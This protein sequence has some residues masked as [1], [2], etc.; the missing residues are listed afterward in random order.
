[1]GSMLDIRR[2]I[3]GVRNIRQ[4]TK[5]MEMVAAAKLRR[6]QDQ[7]VAARP[8][9]G[10]IRKALARLA[11]SAAAAGHPLL[12]RRDIERELLL[13]VTGDRG[14]CGGYNSNALR[15][16]LSYRGEMEH[17]VSLGTVGRRGRDFLRKR[18]YDLVLARISSNEDVDMGFASGLAGEMMR[19]FREG[20]VDRVTIL[21]TQFIS[22][23]TQ[24]L[25]TLELLPV[26]PPLEEGTRPG[27]PGLDY[28]YEPSREVVLE[29]LLPR[30][31]EV[32]VY[33][34]LLESKASEHGA[35]RTAMKN[36][37]DNAEEMIE[38]LTL[39]YNRERQASIT[40]EIAEIVSGV[41]ALK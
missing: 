20:T 4:V 24:R 7:V 34:A 39:E 17:E 37:T 11:D 33:H 19:L 40:A 18:G 25:T 16:G 30:Y 15:R 28:I 1:M 35:R 22:A 31:V 12:Q 6:A 41:E 2:H 5:A 23:L 29:A 27:P 3:R 8:Y 36:A 10:A 38:E 32:Q 21:Y 26:A 9:A 14:L 13:V